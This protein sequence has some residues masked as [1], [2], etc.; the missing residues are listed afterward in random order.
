MRETHDMVSALHY[1]GM[2]VIRLLPEYR[3]RDQE[4][5]YERHSEFHTGFGRRRRAEVSDLQF[6]IVACQS[7]PVRNANLFRDSGCSSLL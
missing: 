5:G 7:P 3:E 6:Q 2:V 4:E 1:S